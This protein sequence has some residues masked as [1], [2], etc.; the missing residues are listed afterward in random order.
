MIQ[1]Q[2]VSLSLH[3]SGL[4]L[5]ETHL[6]VSGVKG[7]EFAVP[8]FKETWVRYQNRQ[9]QAEFLFVPEAGNNLL[10]QDLMPKLGIGLSIIQEQIQV[11]FNLLSTTDEERILPEVWTREGNQGGLKISP[12]WI[13]LK[14]RE[15]AVRRK[16]YPI[17]LQGRL[18]LKPII[19]ELVKDG[20][21]EPCMS[22][23]NTPILPVKKPDGSYHL[24]QDL[25]A[26]NQMVLDDLLL[27][28]SQKEE[29]V[30]ITINLLN[31]LGQQGLRVSKTNL[32]RLNT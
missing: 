20:L 6:P 2:P 22:P 5:S 26:V 16:Q 15:E 18:G 23:F 31:F 12:I 27:S 19:E 14:N 24:V 13:E 21:L 4:N 29:M 30:D 7:E 25:R 32:K 10:G 1:E 8:I 11:S 28:G 9:T 3:P 17:P